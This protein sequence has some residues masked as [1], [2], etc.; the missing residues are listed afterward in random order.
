MGD[1]GWYTGDVGWYT[2]DMGWYTGSIGRWRTGWFTAG[3][4]EEHESE[5]SESI[6]SWYGVGLVALLLGYPSMVPVET[7]GEVDLLAKE[8]WWRRR[9]GGEWRASAELVDGSFVDF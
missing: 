5:Y 8:T 6:A 2:G 7:C 3:G 9:L 1:V 4:D